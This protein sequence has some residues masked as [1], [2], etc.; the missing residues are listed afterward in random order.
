MACL[1]HDFPESP[2]ASAAP[3]RGWLF[4][5]LHEHF[6]PLEHLFHHHLHHLHAIFHHLMHRHHA[7]GFSRPLTLATAHRTHALTTAHHTHT[8][9]A[10]HHAHPHA[11]HHAHG[12]TH[13]LHMLLHKPFTFHRV[14]GFAQLGHE[15]LRL[16]HALLCLGHLR[17]SNVAAHGFVR[18]ALDRR[19][20]A[21]IG[22]MRIIGISH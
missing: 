7:A 5:I 18:C 8:L 3:G 14:F 17:I 4:T 9:A 22:M 11:A 20:T 1:P 21:L 12:V 15:R 19:R 13:G 16:F 6:L 2:G 10:A